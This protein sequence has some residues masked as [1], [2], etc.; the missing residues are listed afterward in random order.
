VSAGVFAPGHLGELTQVIP[1]DLVDGVLADTRAAQRRLRLLPSRVGVYFMLVLGLFPG[2]GY[3]ACG[4]R[5]TGWACPRQ[6]RCGTC[7]DRREPPRFRRWHSSPV[8]EH[9]PV[10]PGCGYRVSD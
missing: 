9:A 4:R 5:W 1:F 7:G 6:R 8:R 2:K 3:R 10:V